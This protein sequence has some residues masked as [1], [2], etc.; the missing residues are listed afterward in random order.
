MF[1]RLSSVAPVKGKSVMAHR[2]GACAI[3]AVLNLAYALVVSLE[4]AE[5]S[6]KLKAIFHEGTTLKYKTTTRARQELSFM[7]VQVESTK[8]ESRRWSRSIGK[9]RDD[10]TLPIEEKVE[11]LRVDYILQG[12]I[13]LTLDSEHPEIKFD[14]AR[15][16]FL[17]D[18]FKLEK[19]LTYVVVLDKGNKVKAIEG[20]QYLRKASERLKDP[21]TR[22]EFREQ[23]SDDRLKV[24]FEQEIHR[25]PEVVPPKGEPWERSEVLEING[26]R[27]TIRRKYEYR[28]TENK[29]GKVLEKIGSHVLD[30]KYDQG[31]RS[32]LPL[33][34]IKSD[35]KIESS[36]GT[37][38]LDRDDRYVV[39][40]SD[41]IKI[42][43][44]VGYSGAG[45]EQT[46][47][48][49]LTFSTSTELQ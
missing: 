8:N 25:L 32:E 5:A 47:E 46:G 13:K 11:S 2:N 23:M 29:G 12:G 44:E 49:N 40:M 34:V 4:A 3:I 6:V 10:T 42:K 20:T 14:N 48:F 30:V 19:A 39:S 9:R 28:G 43:G 33:K 45:V 24:R 36:E 37:I 7:G 18:V 22:A 15:F 26:Q 21:I 35:L 17:S 31:S 1:P 38:L 41:R 27:F 16:A